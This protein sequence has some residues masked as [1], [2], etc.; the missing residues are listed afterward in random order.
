MPKR[1]WNVFCNLG[2][3]CYL[4][5]VETDR[6]GFGKLADSKRHDIIVIQTDF[7]KVFWYLADDVALI[8]I[9]CLI[10]TDICGIYNPN[11][12]MDPLCN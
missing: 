3:Q 7:L 6:Y 2:R 8:W 9:H 4:F 10:K 5:N 12:H 11:P 1:W